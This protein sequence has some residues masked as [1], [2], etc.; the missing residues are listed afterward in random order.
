[1]PDI[2]WW[3]NCQPNFGFWEYELAISG[4]T[5]DLSRDSFWLIK[6]WA[7][8]PSTVRDQIMK[9]MT[10]LLVETDGHVQHAPIIT[11]TSQ[12]GVKF[13][14]LQEAGIDLVGKLRLRW[15]RKRESA[16]QHPSNAD[17]WWSSSKSKFTCIYSQSMCH[18]IWMYLIPVICTKLIR[19]LTFRQI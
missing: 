17:Q 2:F 19:Y 3:R 12:L 5:L 10:Y 13:V 7:L 14:W 6:S 11:E 9:D 18:C 1:M 16:R 15:S 8:G 4:K